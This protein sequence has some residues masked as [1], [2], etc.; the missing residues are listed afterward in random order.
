MR[1]ALNIAFWCRP[2]ASGSNRG[3]P[4]PSVWRLPRKRKARPRTRPRWRTWRR[5]PW[6]PVTSRQSA[7][8][9]SD[10]TPRTAAG[11]DSSL[12]SKRL[13]G[14]LLARFIGPC[15]PRFF[16]VGRKQVALPRQTVEPRQQH[17]LAGTVVLE[18]RR[19]GPRRLIGQRERFIIWRLW[20]F[21]AASLPRSRRQSSIAASAERIEKCSQSQPQV[22][23]SGGRGASPASA[24]QIASSRSWHA[25]A[26]CLPLSKANTSKRCSSALS[27][28]PAPLLVATTT[29]RDGILVSNATLR[30]RWHCG[31]SHSNSSS[32]TKCHPRPLSGRSRSVAL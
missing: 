31:L 12:A 30:Y 29:H 6:S 8:G 23:Q 13:C 9:S 15:Q 27:R 24:R 20:G 26:K 14:F 32:S 10:T 11:L 3:R 28:P 5:T 17:H 1:P 2:P 19:L 21:H 4:R 7:S 22:R 25:W 16:A 18:A